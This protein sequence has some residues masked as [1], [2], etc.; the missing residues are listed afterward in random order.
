MSKHS[1]PQQGP[2]VTAFT[3]AYVEAALFSTND[4]SDQDTGGDPLDQNYGPMDIGEETMEAMRS[5]CADFVKRYG[6]L[7]EDDDSP[8]IQRW[9][10]WSLAGSDFWMTRNSH[11]V[12]FWEESDW[13][14]HGD[15][16]DKA[17]KSYGQFDL[18][19]GDDGEIHG[20][21]LT[22]RRKRLNEVAEHRDSRTGQFAAGPGPSPIGEWAVIQRMMKVYA[23]AKGLGAYVHN[24]AIPTGRS[25]EWR[26]WAQK[27][28][29]R[30]KEHQVSTQHLKNA[31]ERGGLS[32]HRPTAEH[33]RR[34]SVAHRRGNAAPRVRDYDVTD[35]RGKLEEARKRPFRLVALRLA[36]DG[37]GSKNKEVLSTFSTESAA[38]K[39]LDESYPRHMWESWN[40]YDVWIEGLNRMSGRFERLNEPRGLSEQTR[41]RDYDVTDNRGKRLAGPFKDYGQAR[42]EADS[43]GG[44]V[45]FVAG[46][47]EV[48][49]P[50]HGAVAAETSRR[51]G[52][53]HRPAPRRGHQQ[54]DVAVT[55][56]FGGSKEQSSRTAL[57]I[58]DVIEHAAGSKGRWRTSPF[59]GGWAM[60]YEWIDRGQ[61]R[62]VEGAVYGQF[63]NAVRVTQTSVREGATTAMV[64]VPVGE[65]RHYAE[66]S[67]RRAA[68]RQHRGG[69]RAEASRRASRKHTT[70]AHPRRQHSVLSR[71]DA[72]A[73]VA[74]AR[75]QRVRSNEVDAEEAGERFAEEQVQS[76]HFNQWVYGQM[77]EGRRMRKADPKSVIQLESAADY[78][79]L[80]R[81][82]LQ[83]LGWDMDRDMDMRAILD[84]VGVESEGTTQDAEVAREFAKGVR[85]MLFKPSTINSLASDL[86]RVETE[87]KRAERGAKGGGRKEASESRGPKLLPP[88]RR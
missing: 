36:G 46:G 68:P 88:A 3:I 64:A 35:N 39:A 2:D 47:H 61:Y 81:N 79:R 16:L 11:G 41:V 50:V 15:E 74:E 69:Y 21:P 22:P 12:G 10:E 4:E 24:S 20:S 59:D 52:G 5:D 1:H 70:T 28:G 29:E 87:L 73:M 57:S 58:A 83:Q 25:G 31:Y 9:G 23:E 18:Y 53:R 56:F 6:H 19:V 13:P 78:K 71:H 51:T 65:A 17:A 86:R 44:V 49:C 80:A 54:G 27:P 34:R 33:H 7:I 32:E 82:I 37:Y 62:T 85:A 55:V 75:R 66:A 8:D 26:F 48:E 38:K 63:G 84:A 76:D 14:K 40:L 67:R 30:S 60:R 45:G 42:S 77:V 72:K 43:R